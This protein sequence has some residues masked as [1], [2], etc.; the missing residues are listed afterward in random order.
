MKIVIIGGHLAPALSVL[1]ALPKD[2]QIL[3]IGRKYAL[4][5][6]K[7]LSLE[8]KT[9]SDLNIPFVGLNTGRWQRKFTKFTISSLLKIP[10]GIIKS[11]L[12]LIKFKPDVVVGF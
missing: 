10:S 5:G 6:E 2:T 12:I 4:E 11:F 1:E 9:M 7:T 8:Y 3:F